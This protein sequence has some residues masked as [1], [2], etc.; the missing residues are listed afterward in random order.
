MFMSYGIRV[1]LKNRNVVFLFENYFK[2]ELSNDKVHKLCVTHG[3]GW[4]FT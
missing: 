2:V 1:K 3:R 4:S